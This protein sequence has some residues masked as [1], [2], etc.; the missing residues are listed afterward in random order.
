MFDLYSV[1]KRF[2]DIK[3]N[4]IDEDGESHDVKL[5]VRPAKLK[6]LNKLIKLQKDN[7]GESAENITNAV[8]SLLSNNKTGYIVPDEIVEELDLDQVKAILTAYINWMSEEKN[9][10][11]N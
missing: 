11:P 9:N 2:F 3:F 5:Q 7:G 6:T 1:K 4:Y 10:D 8:K